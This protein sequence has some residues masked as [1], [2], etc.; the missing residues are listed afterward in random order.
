MDKLKIIGVVG[1]LILIANVFLFAFRI[2]T[3]LIFW[4]IIAV[5]AALVYVGLP[6]WKNFMKK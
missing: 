2:I 1:T 4:I 5:M 6:K 3:P